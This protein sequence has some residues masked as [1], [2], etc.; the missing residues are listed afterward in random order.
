MKLISSHTTEQEDEGDYL[1]QNPRALLMRHLLA[2]CP[3]SEFQSLQLQHL[4]QHPVPLPHHQR[5][6]LGDV[7]QG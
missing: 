6:L 3:D 7:Q 2:G 4:T 1:R 5:R